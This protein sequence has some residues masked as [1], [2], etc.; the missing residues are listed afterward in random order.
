MADNKE[1]LVEFN[2]E[3]G[4]KRLEEINAKLADKS[5]TL[6]DSLD[7]YKEGV[8]LAAKCKEQLEGI[9]HELQV[10]NG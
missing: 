6:K 3:E 4:L 5:I 7:L 10:I 2:V 8:E 1:N 9:E